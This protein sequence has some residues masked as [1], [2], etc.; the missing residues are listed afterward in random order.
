[1]LIIRGSTDVYKLY[2]QKVLGFNQ[3]FKLVVKTKQKVCQFNNIQSPEGRSTANS[4]CILTI[5]Q[6]KDSSQ[7]NCSVMDQQL[8]QIFNQSLFFYTVVFMIELESI[9]K[10]RTLNWI[11]FQPYI[12]PTVKYHSG[13]SSS[14]L[15]ALFKWD[16][17]VQSLH[18]KRT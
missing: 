10:V 8:S 13:I 15:L 6:A 2:M 9:Q 12:K 4:Q 3:P 16:V 7:H 17:N 11:S 5:P 18:A 14:Y 1:M